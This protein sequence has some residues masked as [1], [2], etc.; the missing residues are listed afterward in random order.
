MPASE[1]VYFHGAHFAHIVEFEE[2]R[3]LARI[4]EAGRRAYLA[5]RR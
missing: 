5:R 4:A 3:R 2:R 1:A